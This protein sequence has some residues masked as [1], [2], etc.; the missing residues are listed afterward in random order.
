MY[1]FVVNAPSYGDPHGNKSINSVINLLPFSV[2]FF[3]SINL[4]KNNTISIKKQI[5]N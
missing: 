1:D 5:K 2:K 3:I 4:Y